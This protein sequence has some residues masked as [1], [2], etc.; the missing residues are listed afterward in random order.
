MYR[1][2]HALTEA[3]FELLLAVDETVVRLRGSLKLVDQIA[4]EPHFRKQHIKK[5]VAHASV[6]PVEERQLT[7]SPS[8]SLRS[9]E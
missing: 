4:D 7:P 3:I 2:P 1:A 6:D 8:V 9:F 5:I